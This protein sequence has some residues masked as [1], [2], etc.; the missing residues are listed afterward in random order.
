MPLPGSQET[1]NGKASGDS[2]GP[3]LVVKWHFSL[4]A[5]PHPSLSQFSGWLLTSQGPHP[6]GQVE[7]K[8]QSLL[9][10]LCQ[11]PGAGFYP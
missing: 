8:T 9:C 11:V 5:F 7:T 3:Q 1:N 4:V 6:R 2:V 10:S